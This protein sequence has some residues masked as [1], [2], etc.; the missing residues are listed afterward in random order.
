VT[1]RTPKQY[2]W[3]KA[4]FDETLLTKHFRAKKSR[5]I[6][7]IVIHHMTIV[8]KGTGAAND[9]CYKTWQTRKASAHYGIDGEFVRQFVWDKDVAW[10]TGSNSGNSYG[11]SIE[12][13]NSEAAPR[14]TISSTSLATS[15]RLTARLHYLH[16]LGRPRS[17]VTLKRHRDFKA[18]E[19]PG[20][21]LVGR[22]SA[23]V[24][25]C[26]KQYDII[27]GVSPAPN[28]APTPKVR[29]RVTAAELNGRTGPGMG[30]PVKVVRKRGSQFSSSKQSGNWVQAT[31]Y[32]YHISHLETVAPPRPT[33]KPQRLTLGT[34][35]IPLDSAKIENGSARAKIAARQVKDAGISILAV[36]ELDRGADASA[37]VFATQLLGALGSGWA[38]VKPTTK[39]NENYIFY[40]MASVKY[41]T[42]KSDLI[43]TS[44]AGGRHA[45]RAVFSLAGREFTVFSTHLVSGAATK[46]REDQGR[47]LAA[48]GS[49]ST[50]I[51]GDL[52]QKAIPP[53][54]LKGYK[55]ARAV[56]P[57]GS[58]SRYGTFASWKRT[59]AS[60]GATSFLDHILVP[61]KI[62]VI[63]ANVVGV[64]ADGKLTQPRASD[65]L[66]V[67]ATV[68]V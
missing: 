60:T 12:H 32:W 42:R 49:A 43:L 18:T 37:H 17:G 3:A 11:I 40:R 65:H 55:S 9:A 26:Q 10:A 19:C 25:E 41:V 14:W 1:R 58:L 33:P 34:L 53:A 36:Q 28:P 48:H 4:E 63:G 50:F 2:N 15:A 20:P 66:L 61:M 45:T 46:A 6:K 8:G 59:S 27:A 22:W 62:P 23:Y 68:E 64:Q 13:A 7:F 56:Q 54:L 67:V 29:Y 51:L 24:S 39:W 38:V 35:N 16:K 5:K 30:F 31:K 52:N 44:S 57:V 21:Y 47:Q